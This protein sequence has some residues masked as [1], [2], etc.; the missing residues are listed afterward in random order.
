[1]ESNC[2]NTL[3]R[4]SLLASAAGSAG[5]ALVNSAAVADEQTKETKPRVRNMSEVKAEFDRLLPLWQK[6]RKQYIYSSD[7]FDY[8]QGPHGKAII[9]LGPAIIPFLIQQVKG[10]DFWFNVPLF[11]FTQVDISDGKLDSEQADSK[12]WVE[13]WDIGNKQLKKL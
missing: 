7:T 5:A 11:H 2:A 10:G 9:A 12:R 8:W 1:M 3:S 6:E 4:R 13:W